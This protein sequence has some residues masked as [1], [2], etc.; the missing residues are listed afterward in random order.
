MQT[1]ERRQAQEEL[2]R[3]LCAQQG[4]GAVPWLAEDCDRSLS[5]P[6]LAAAP[7]ARPAVVQASV[8]R[9]GRR[10]GFLALGWV[11][12][13]LGGVGVVVPGLPTT[14]FLLVALWAFARSDPRLH[15]WLYR[16]P[17]FGPPLRA[18]HGH[19]VVPWRAKLGAATAMAASLALLWLGGA[20]PVVLAGVATIL[21]AVAAFLFSRPSRVPLR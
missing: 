15:D 20:A 21:L 1:A 2:M 3:N 4:D 13:T 16:H 18:W 14:V 17:R 10:F 9:P 7:I 12:L 8:M 6:D 5:A 11:C 19:R